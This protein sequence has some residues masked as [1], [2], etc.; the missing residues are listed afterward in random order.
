MDLLTSF[1]L[2]LKVSILCCIS[3]S[4]SAADKLSLADRHNLV[5]RI[6]D[7]GSVRVIIE[8]RGNKQTNDIESFPVKSGKRNLNPS[9]QNLQDRIK[10]KLS[11]TNAQ[12]KLE[13]NYIPF[14]VYVIDEN[15]LTLLESL[16]ELVSI[17]V[18]NLR[19][20]FLSESIPLIG[21]DNAW[22]QGYSGAGT[23]I[24]IIDSGIDKTHDFIAN[25]VVSEACYSTTTSITTSLCPSGNDVDELVGSGINCNIDGCYHGTH[26]AGI[27]TG[28]GVNFS[29]IAK[30]ADIISIQVFSTVY[31]E[32]FCGNTNPCLGAFDS[33][34]I[35]GLERVYELINDYNIP[36]VNLS[37]GGPGF[38]TQVECDANNGGYL[39]A[40]TNLTDA[41]VAV[42]ISS[43]NDS[44][45]N[46]ISVP[47]CVTGAISVGASNNNDEI[48]SF[49]NL[50][51][52]LSYLAPG[53]A[54]NSSVLNDNYAQLSGTSMAAPHVAGAIAVLAAHENLP[55][56]NEILSVLTNS[57]KGITKGATTYPRIQLDDALDLLSD[58]N[59]PTDTI[60]MDLIISGDNGEEVY[61]NGSYLGN[62]NSW[63]TASSY[64]VE[65]NDGDNVIA[66]K[67]IDVDGV[68]ALIAELQV[69]GETFYSDSSW[70]VSTVYQPGWEA[71]DF[72]DSSWTNATKYG[73]YGV[74]P[75]RSR[76]SG[77]T[78]GSPAKWIWSADNDGDN[79][80]YFRYTVSVESNSPLDPVSIDTLALADGEVNQPYTATLI[81]SGGIESYLW[82]VT[83]GT[84]PDGLA[85]NSDTGAI[86]GTPTTEGDSNFTITFEDSAI[87]SITAD[88]NINIAPQEVID[89]PLS[90]DT[91][92]LADGEVNQ[93]YTATL[94]GSGGS[95]SYL[96]SVT[97]G[98]L[99]DG[100]ALNIDTGAITGTPTTEGD[101]NFTITLEDSAS[102]SI[103]ADFNINIAPQE[104]IDVPLSI[105]TPSLADGE[106]NQLYSATLVGSGGTESYLWSVTTGTLPDGLALNSDTGA[107]TGT[108]T[109]EGDSNF[110]ITF[111]D[112]ASDSIT[113][114]FTI[115]IAAERDA[116]PIT[117]DLII[118]G[119][120]GEEVYV[121]GSYLGNSNSW[122]TASSYTVELNDGDNVIAV[123]GIDVDGVAALIAELQVDGETFYSDSSWKVSTVYQPGWEAPDFDDSSWTNA[124]KY[125]SYGVSPWRSRV[126]GFTS[127]SPAKWIW[128]AD[129][130]GDNTVY[131]RYTVSVE[132][133][134]PLDPVSI[135]TLALADGEVNQLYSA[136]LVGS[137]GTDSYLWS[138]TTG[139]LPDGLALN[140][141]TGAIT[142]TPT[143]E[144][145][146]NF[147]ITLE[148]SAIDSITAD[149]TINIAAERDAKPITMDLIISGDNGEE[150]YVNGSYLGNSNSWNTASSYTVEL[151]DGDN[152]IAV[153]GI[154]VDGVA[155]LIAELQVDG[156]TFY[157]DSSWK[158]STVYQP[159]WEAPDFDDS[160]WTNATEYGS[161]GVSP[162][163]SGVSGLTN[164]SPAKW[165][166]SAD[167]D[168][169]NTVYFRYT[170]IDE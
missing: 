58:N 19:K 166:W 49:S 88:F 85:L 47:A 72:D 15:T 48:A 50:A 70:K 7:N 95:E 124:T 154:D 44:K 42:V 64:T 110:T 33:N 76:V 22:S 161:Y 146:S 80:V 105:D 68:A 29:G 132:S 139:T 107:I 46:Q 14:L 101:S 126:S 17:Q 84:L 12:L 112:S 168:G 100:L 9:L 125:G 87:D 165:I 130:D 37:L 78:S 158:V 104:V 143:T 67:G 4:V 34:V 40:I 69:D 162:W 116:K 63:N 167:N 97:T 117:M 99:P 156:E 79:T 155:A 113:A 147:T 123:K 94:I 106:V 140:S 24:A 89:V 62:S 129:N 1:R 25:K 103:T 45:G 20:P 157:S 35:Q 39:S 92:S 120:N 36:A 145:D 151:N 3:V 86:T 119:D 57:A 77:F 136:T 71:P 141:D 27:A 26:V 6:H 38:S 150:V 82:S 164:G 134:S 41:G 118:S 32:E 51:P 60:T 16:D 23:T 21:A 131:F 83:T 127:G 59:N 144:G 43:G 90:I 137:G 61:V 122:N 56:L 96:W 121:N 11:S 98:T 152:V 169:D 81:G 66:V 93:P 108:P 28:V 148:D 91:P 2:F 102:D 55:S 135:D 75:W 8:L 5:S 111:E 10:T 149:F 109:T 13:F 115:N 128:S 142:G 133:N 31:S 18:D 159:G 138:V 153:K 73:S 53:V 52:F 74:S 65:L 114:D 30:D 170:L 54:I 163:R 160:S